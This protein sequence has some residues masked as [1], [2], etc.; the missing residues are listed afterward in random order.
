MV[1]SICGYVAENF[2]DY[3]VHKRAGH[4]PTYIQVALVLVGTVV[5]TA[6][7]LAA[8]QEVPKLVRKLS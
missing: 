5:L 4:L 8:V 2:M 6:L 7:L 3:E 1:C